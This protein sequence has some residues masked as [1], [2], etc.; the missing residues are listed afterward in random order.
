MMCWIVISNDG[1]GGDRQANS[2]DIMFLNLLSP[3]IQTLHATFS[4][5]DWHKIVSTFKLRSFLFYLAKV[6]L[7]LCWCWSCSCLMLE[8]IQSAEWEDS[9]RLHNCCC[10]WSLFFYLYLLLSGFKKGAGRSVKTDGLGYALVEHLGKIS[11]V[12]AAWRS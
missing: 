8:K 6:L 12:S 4:N 5:E 3:T 1:Q 2:V 10:R 11:F 7:E 9:R